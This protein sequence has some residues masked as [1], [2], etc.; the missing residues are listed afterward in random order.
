MRMQEGFDRA[1]Y[2]KKII[3]E[4]ALNKCIKCKLIF[5]DEDFQYNLA[6]I[7]CEH[8]IHKSCL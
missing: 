6:Q 4:A 2:E 7:D 8:L 3:S 5:K 1:N